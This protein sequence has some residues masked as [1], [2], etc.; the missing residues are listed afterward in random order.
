[1]KLT[2][3]ELAAALAAPAAA[4]AATEAQ[5]PPAS[6]DLLKAAQDRVTESGKILSL[7][8]VPIT[9]EPAFQFKA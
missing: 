1:M 6:G 9:T 7:E 2:R 3:R 8:A 5:T 4:L